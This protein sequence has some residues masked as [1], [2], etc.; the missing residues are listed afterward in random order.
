MQQKSRHAS[1][2]PWLDQYR[3]RKMAILR[4]TVACWSRRFR[5]RSYGRRSAQRV[6]K[7]TLIG[8]QPVSAAARWQREESAVGSP[9]AERR[10]CGPRRFAGLDTD[11]Q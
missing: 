6:R 4:W 10:D 2:E 7:G 11:R 1:G 5:W 9:L 8:E 3:G